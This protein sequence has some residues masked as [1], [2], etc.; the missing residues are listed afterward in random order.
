[1]GQVAKSAAYGSERLLRDK[2]Q[3]QGVDFFLL[4]IAGYKHDTKYTFPNTEEVRGLD[5]CKSL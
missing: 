4:L 1:M 2:L 3:C 5:Q